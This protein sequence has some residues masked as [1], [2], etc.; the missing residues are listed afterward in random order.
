M[1]PCLSVSRAKGYKKNACAGGADLNTNYYYCISVSSSAHIYG[2]IRGHYDCG[3]RRQSHAWFID[4]SAQYIYI[5]IEPKVDCCC[6][7]RGSL[8]DIS[9]ENPF[10]RQGF[11]WYIWSSTLCRKRSA[12]GKNIGTQTWANDL[13]NWSEA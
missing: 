10:N 5:Y 2:H 1:H 11:R 8:E 9:K 12:M 4:R 13:A 7:V 6:P 3:K